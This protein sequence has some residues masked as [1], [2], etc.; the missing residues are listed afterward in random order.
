MDIDRENKD[1]MVLNFRLENI[2]SEV[3][4]TCLFDV[5]PVRTKKSQTENENATTISTINLSSLLI[6]IFT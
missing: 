5:F 6:V 2:F 3:E 4:V 1:T